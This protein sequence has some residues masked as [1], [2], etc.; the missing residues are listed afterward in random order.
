LGRRLEIPAGCLARR[1]LPL[2]DLLVGGGA[3]HPTGLPVAVEAVLEV[4]GPGGER[5]SSSEHVDLSD[6]R[7]EWTTD[8]A[9][10]TWLRFSKSW[11]VPH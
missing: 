9:F 5:S 2:A 4:D 11:D 3:L 8:V 10:L 6:R 1:H 7:G